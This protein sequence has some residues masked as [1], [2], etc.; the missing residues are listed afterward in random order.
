MKSGN[1]FW[2]VLLIV[3]GALIF[4][5]NFDIFYFSWGSILRLWPLLFVFWGISVLPVKSGLRLLLSIATVALGFILLV[6]NPNRGI[7]WNNNWN[8][9]VRIEHDSDD[10]AWD[11]D[12]F[13]EDYDD[14]IKYATLNL[15]A[16]AGAYSINGTTSKL[17]EFKTEGNG[18]PYRANVNAIADDEVKIEFSRSKVRARDNIRNNVYMYLNEE[19]LWTMKVDVGAADVDL[20]LSE[21]RVDEIEIDGGAADIEVK[22]G[23][24][25]NHIDVS[26]DAGVADLSILVPK[27]SAVEV[28]T[29]TVLSGR[30]F[31]GFNKIDN[32]LYQ[33][34]NFSD[35]ANQ[36]M[37]EIQA[38]VS[39]VTIERY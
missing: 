23:D 11:E 39:G 2:G 5:R 36:I 19:P 37:I 8:K 4:M 32:G 28:V 20:D 16:A 35:S 9:H 24:K 13:E 34:P 29:H 25:H 22:L 33:T 1:I 14:D 12:I 21:F 3:F 17:F 18:G 6:S 15:T 31:E 38:A 27:E 10:N 7:F 30:D 26:I